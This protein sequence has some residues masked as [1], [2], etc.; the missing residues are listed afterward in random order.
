MTIAR[1]L[2]C[3]VL[4]TTPGLADD[5]GRE[6]S[7]EHRSALASI[8]SN[9]MPP[10]LLDGLTEWSG[11]P[12]EVTDLGGQVALIVTWAS[13]YK[14]SHSALSM[15]SRLHEAHGEEGLVVIAA[16]HPRGW[17]AAQTVIDKKQAGDIACAWDE[18][19][20]LRELLSIDGDPDY[21]LIDRAGTVRFADITTDSVERAV[22]RLL[23]E[24]VEDAQAAGDE[25][26]PAIALGGAAG[27]VRPG[28]ALTI[29]FD[30]PDAAEYADV[31][32]PKV[33]PPNGFRAIDVQGKPL[34]AALGTETYLGDEPDRRGRVV[35]L[36][37]WATWCGP[38]RT[39]MPKLDELQTDHPNDLVVIGISNESRQKV[40]GFLKANPHEYAQAIDQ[41]STVASALR[42]NAIPHIVVLST[43]GVVRWQGNPLAQGG[44][45]L[46]RAVEGCMAVDPGVA[47]R[48]QAEERFLKDA[49][50]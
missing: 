37:F 18:E 13:W 27:G 5:I 39:A 45:A 32:W 36:D 47:A 22:E 33:G 41:Q 42:I 11:T 29:P 28:A 34:P 35:V 15:A 38:C 40:E 8:E 44:A 10:A 6:G 49:S 31:A 14:T 48:R 4:F 24:S 17:S 9:P 43:D 23:A 26:A 1:M 21:Y 12:V 20:A 19:G 30:L 7:D 50:G 3:A 16:H 25:A 46:R 2:S